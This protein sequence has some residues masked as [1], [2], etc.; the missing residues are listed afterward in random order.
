M[1]APKP[2][3]PSVGEMVPL[4]RRRPKD[5]ALLELDTGDLMALS[6]SDVDE[7]TRM[8]ASVLATMTTGQRALL[9]FKARPR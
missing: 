8:L 2:N 9:R 7:S 6:Q 1:S 5:V 3:P 4:M